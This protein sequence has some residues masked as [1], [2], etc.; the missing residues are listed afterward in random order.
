MV[1]T[2]SRPG[3][4]LANRGDQAGNDARQPSQ[5]VVQGHR[6]HEIVGL[7]AKE[8]DKA[9]RVEIE[10]VAEED[11]GRLRLDSGSSAKSRRFA[12]VMTCAPA[13]TAAAAT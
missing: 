13:L 12:V 9:L 1:A 6:G 4:V 8:L 3:E 10:Q 11:V 2:S 5:Q 7:L